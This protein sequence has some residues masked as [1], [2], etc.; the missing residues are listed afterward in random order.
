M[1]CKNLRLFL[2]ALGG[3]LS[4]QL[5]QGHLSLVV[6]MKRTTILTSLFD[7]AGNAVYLNN[8]LRGNSHTNHYK[9]IPAVTIIIIIIIF[10]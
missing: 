6:L 7:L 2:E 5:Q 9:P 4:L 10:I 3:S 1:F 8:F